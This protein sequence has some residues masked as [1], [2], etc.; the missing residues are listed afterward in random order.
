MGGLVA[1]TLR[2]TTPLSTGQTEYRGSCWT[3]TLP[4]GLFNAAFYDPAT[5]EDHAK[6]WIEALLTNR[7]E[8]PEVAEMWGS[9]GKL[10]PVGYGIIVVDYVSKTALSFQNYCS[11]THIHCFDSHNR[12][13]WRKL[14]KRGL[15]RKEKRI[16]LRRGKMRVA[17]IDASGTFPTIQSAESNGITRKVYR[18]LAG[19]FQLTA[20]EDAAWEKWFADREDN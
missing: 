6:Q 13:K 7:A 20:D 2:F 9:W 12:R 10:A 4:D 5:S 8:D 17:K 18:D 1:I 3:N 14:K 15:L 11:P 16:R 19:L